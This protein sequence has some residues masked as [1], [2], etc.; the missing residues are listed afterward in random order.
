[1]KMWGAFLLLACALGAAG[2]ARGDT[3]TLV[4]GRVLEGRATRT[5]NGR[6]VIKVRLGEVTVDAR[7]VVKIEAGATLDE[8]YE[9]ARAGCD[10]SDP[11]DLERLAAWCHD[12]GL[13]GRARA[14]AADAGRLRAEQEAARRAAEL[15]SRRA[16]AGKDAAALYQTARWAEAESYGDGVVEA[17]LREALLAD[18]EYAR[19][20]V[21][22][23]LRAKQVEADRQLAL[24][25]ERAEEQA[26]EA[27]RAATERAA[28]EEERARAAAARQEADARLA[29][30][31][32]DQAAA[33]ARRAE[34]EAAAAAAEEQRRLA[35]AQ[36]EATVFVGASCAPTCG[37]ERHGSSVTCGTPIRGPA[38]IAGWRATPCRVQDPGR[39]DCPPIHAAR[40]GATFGPV[41]VYRR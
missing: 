25:R 39:Y 15:A 26:E 18:P 36:A 16:A 11:D 37:R 1:M 21:A 35:E 38:G 9:A 2:V 33:A 19:A 29:A 13:V 12:N 17:L 8:R 14:L 41:V 3:I 34:A 28:A 40:R 6:V 30:A 31:Q 5:A 24:A 23:E 7:D 10:L 32:A 22:L 20:Q 27:R 4:D